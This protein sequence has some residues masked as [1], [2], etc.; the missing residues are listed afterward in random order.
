MKFIDIAIAILCFVLLIFLLID[1][2]KYLDINKYYKNVSRLHHIIGL[3]NDIEIRNK[4]I[5]DQIES[6]DI[7]MSFDDDFTDKLIKFR[8]EQDYLELLKNEQ[9]RIQIYLKNVR[10]YKSTIG[11]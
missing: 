4:Y 6:M 3:I 7:E 5:L 9:K 1:R 2:K 10:H 11:I 8:D